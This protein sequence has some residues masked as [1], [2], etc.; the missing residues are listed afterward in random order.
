MRIFV[1]FSLIPVPCSLFPLVW[2]K[3]LALCTSPMMEAK[4]F[5]A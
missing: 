4:Q 3:S 1:P 2:Q 5:G